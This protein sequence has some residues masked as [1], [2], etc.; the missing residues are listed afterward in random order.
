MHDLLPL[1]VGIGLTYGL[2]A[3][4]IL[5]IATGGLIVPGYFALHLMNP[6][7]LLMTLAAAVLANLALFARRRAEIY[8]W[9]L[10]LSGAFLCREIHF[11]GSSAI[12]FATPALLAAI[13]WFVYERLPRLFPGRALLLFGILFVVGI[14]CGWVAD[15]AAGALKIKP[16]QACDRLIIHKGEEVKLLVIGDGFVKE[17]KAAG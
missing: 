6:I 9:L 1:S 4:E 13:A 5:G 14:T 10:V 7:H 16:C 12:A 17:K 3:T 11:P 8:A 15:R 2:L